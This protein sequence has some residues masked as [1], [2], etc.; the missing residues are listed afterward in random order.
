MSV[1]P[2]AFVS[3]Q[4]GAFDNALS[5]VERSPLDQD[6]DEEREPFERIDR[7]VTVDLH[8]TPG[9]RFGLSKRSFAV[10]DV[11]AHRQRE[12]VRDHRSAAQWLCAASSSAAWRAASKRSQYASTCET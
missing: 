7:P 11:R 12:A 5:L 10:A 9:I 6:V 4:G 8:A 1:V 2:A 3:F